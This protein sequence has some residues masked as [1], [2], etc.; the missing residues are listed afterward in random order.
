MA[1]VSATTVEAAAT[2]VEATTAMI[3]T[4]AVE[5]AV[6]VIAATDVAMTS[7]SVAGPIA[8]ASTIES[9]MAPIT[10]TVVA[11]AP[12]A[13]IPGAGTDE[14]AA[15][16]VVRAIVAVGGASVRIITKVAIRA[17]RRRSDGDAD[18]AYS[19]ADSNLGMRAGRSSQ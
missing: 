19:N 17:D 14:D 15:Y 5:S 2:A 12:I 3:A 18:G 16:K 8:V 9:R 7:V 4:V 10:V 6:A 13:V 1:T 11:M